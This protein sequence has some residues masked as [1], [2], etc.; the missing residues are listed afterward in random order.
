M[1][2]DMKTRRALI[3]KAAGRYGKASKAEKSQIL[4]E[5]MQWTRSER[6]A[7]VRALR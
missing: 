2:S 4:D 7:L 3:G 5:L 6:S 1:A